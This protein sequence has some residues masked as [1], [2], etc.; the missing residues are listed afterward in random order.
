ML[1]A[2]Q[3][4]NGE[5]EKRIL[6]FDHV[7]EPIRQPGFCVGM[8]LISLSIICECDKAFN[9]ISKHCGFSFI[10]FQKGIE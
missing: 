3:W 7:D 1:N 8:M 10:E 6:N 9:T 4:I 2:D 5:A